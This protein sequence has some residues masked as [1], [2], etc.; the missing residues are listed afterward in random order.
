MLIAKMYLAALVLL[1]AASSPVAYT[2]YNYTLQF[3]LLNGQATMVPDEISS[4][5]YS[6]LNQN[7]F[8]NTSF[9][10]SSINSVTLNGVPVDWGIQFDCDGNPLLTVQHYD[11]LPPSANATLEISFSIDLSKPEF[12]LQN[13]GNISDVP[14]DLID[15][16]PMAGVWNL[17]EA[18]Y[19]SAIID[20]AF[21]I[22]GDEENVLAI[23]L[24]TLQW[25]E[26][27]ISYSADLSVPQSISDTFW[28][29]SGDCDDQANLF[30]AFCRILGIPAYSE[31]GPIYMPG[32]DYQVEGNLRFNLTNV[33]YHGWA[34]VYLP[35][36]DGGEWVPVDLT[37]FKNAYF[38]NGHIKSINLYDHINNSAIMYYDSLVLL[39]VLTSD[40]VD[41]TIALKGMVMRSDCI[42]I[43]SHSMTLLANGN[44]AYSISVYY[45][46]PFV[47]LF[48]LIA[49][50][51]LIQYNYRKK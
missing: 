43:E 48:S 14:V 35:S 15:D 4:P 33:G 19:A 16:Y 46:M 7:V 42:W 34:V 50:T 17:S 39:D 23:V 21:A 49:L 27:N 30:A 31:I 26:D 36:S 5:F 45:V 41:D 1:L 29:K 40:Y 9:Q 38:V 20:T 28:L 3:T 12:D 32:S 2:Q 13:I 51:V 10:T 24:K 25:F 44:P 22:K 47:A 6:L 18:E 8:R 11:S 37:F